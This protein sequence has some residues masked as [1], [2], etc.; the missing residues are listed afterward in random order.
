[1]DVVS[2]QI[3]IDARIG[4][5]EKITGQLD[6]AANKK[7][8]AIGEYDKA[9]AI[10][11]AKLALGTVKEVLGERIDGK[12][13]ATLIKKLA[14]GMCFKERIAQELATSGYKSVLTKIEV[15]QATL[16]GKQSIFRHLSHT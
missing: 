16:N 1:M 10:A 12:P 5:L 13:P 3:S 14:E 7:A 4:K 11:T 6:D 8:L 15:L 2:V 9:V